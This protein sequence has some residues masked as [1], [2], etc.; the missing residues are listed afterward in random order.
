MTALRDAALGYAKR[1]WPVFPCEPRGKRP[2][3]RLV[4]HGLKDATTDAEQV[5]AWWR[6][7]PEANI[8]IATG[9]AFDVLDVDGDAGWHSLA[10][11]IDASGCLA[12]S[13]VVFTPGGGGHY[14]FRPTGVGNRAGF[15]PHLDWRGA[16]GYVVA[17]PSAHPNG[18]SYWWVLPADETPLEAAPAWL[19]RLL[20][21]PQ[22]REV[23]PTRTG[24]S[25]SYGRQALQ[26][27]CGRVALA[28]VG[29]RNDTLVRAAFRMGQLVTA[30]KVDVDEAFDNLVTAADRA[31]LSRLEAERTV[32]SGMSA[33]LKAPRTVTS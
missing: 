4:P 10:N 14:L 32:E 20:R 17:P 25:S 12:S 9:I 2:L 16:G 26:A 33:G 5:R 1:G 23:E 30:H 15:R 27:E 22:R 7:A 24:R 18:G 19:V 29:Q 8:G 21:Q 3:G 13:P 28:T 11:V 31:G 6:E